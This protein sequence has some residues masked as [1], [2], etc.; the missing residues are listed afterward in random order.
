MLLLLNKLPN[1][2]LNKSKKMK[3]YFLIIGIVIS[4]LLMN[5]ANY[6]SRSVPATEKTEKNFNNGYITQGS[7]NYTGSAEEVKALGSNYTLD[8]YL[9]RVSGVNIQGDGANARITIHGINS[10]MADTSPLFVVNGSAMV[11][12]YSTVY[13]L[14][15]PNDIKSV[16]VLKDASSTGIYGSRGSNGVIVITLKLKDEG[17]QVN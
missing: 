15:T 17:A 7:R 4:S 9:R 11:G 1:L 10:F 16:T 5:C 12:G 6:G 14:V 8:N 2:V 13:N 3:S